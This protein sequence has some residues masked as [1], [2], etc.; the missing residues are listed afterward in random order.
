MANIK[1]LEVVSATGNVE[2]TPF[3][4]DGAKKTIHIQATSYGT[5]GKIVLKESPNVDGAAFVTVRDPN[6]VSGLAEYSADTQLVL[7]RLPA[8]W[9]IRADIEISSG[10]MTNAL[11]VMGG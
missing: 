6:T 1:I 10:T 3:N 7:D 5:N 9:K 2:G 4:L 8:G 11:V